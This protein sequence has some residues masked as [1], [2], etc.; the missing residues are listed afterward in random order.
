MQESLK[1]IPAEGTKEVEAELFNAK[2]SPFLRY[3]QYLAVRG[4]WM[5]EDVLKQWIDHID[6]PFE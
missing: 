4:A 2:L 5:S 3:E 6:F 1:G